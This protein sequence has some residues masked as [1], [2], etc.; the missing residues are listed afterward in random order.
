MS[1]LALIER[2]AAGFGEV[3]PTYRSQPH[4]IEAEQAVLGAIL[5]NNEAFHRVV[6]FLH[7]DHFYEPVHGRIFGCCAQR[8]A[9]GMLADPVT[10]AALR[11]P[12]STAAAVRRS[13]IRLL[14]QEP[15]KTTSIGTSCSAVPGARPM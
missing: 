5:V 1:Q 11:C 8:I 14:V 13:S 4:N 10:L 12:R 9:N 7:Q 6:D 15:M 2:P 3:A